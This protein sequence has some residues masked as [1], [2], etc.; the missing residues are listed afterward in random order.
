MIDW[1]A[2]RAAYPRMTYAEVA[3]FHDRIW[4]RHPD[5]RHC[6]PDLLAAFFATVA[7]G[8]AVL[9]VGGWRG[10][11]AAHILA[12]R[13]DLRSW[14]NLEICRGAVGQPVLD[15]PRY[16]GMFPPAWAWD[17]ALIERHEVAVLAHL[18]E[19]ISAA[20][21]GRLVPWLAENGVRQVYVESPLADGPRSWRRSTTAHLLEIGWE[22]VVALF[23]E[24]GYRV[25]HRESYAANRTVLF[26]G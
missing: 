25:K 2:Y 11:M 15:D 19:H 12:Q 3:D 1:D 5:Q 20:Q 10:E 17:M 26:F 21:L 22:G 8:V 16:R 13:P 9:E 6:S 14:L 7:S 18:I 4:A 23:G 24:H